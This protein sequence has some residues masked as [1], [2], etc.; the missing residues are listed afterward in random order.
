MKELEAN[1]LYTLFDVM[2]DIYPM[3]AC[4]L[5]NKNIFVRSFYFFVTRSLAPADPYSFSQN[6]FLAHVRVTA[7]E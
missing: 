4:F 7:R 5:S 2:L 6:F 1:L 3:K